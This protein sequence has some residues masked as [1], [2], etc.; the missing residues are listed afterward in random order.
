MKTFN[1]I[2]TIAL[3][4]SSISWAGELKVDAGKSSLKW[5]ASKI[6]G[7]HDGAVKIKSGT[8]KTEGEKLVSGKVII[9]MSTITVRDI[10][11]AE[12]NAKLVGHLNSADFFDTKQFKSSVLVIEKVELVK[13]DQYTVSGQ[14]MIKGYTNPVTFPATIKMSKDGLTAKAML[15]IDRTKWEIKYGSANFF[16]GLGD[17][18]IHNEI[19]FE[20]DLAAK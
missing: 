15:E 4:V 3:L 1:K 8:L 12:Y 17:K 20:V 2:A 14:L 5:F 19:K 9:D 18:A 13:G 6:T 11:S 10:E 16:K 7:K